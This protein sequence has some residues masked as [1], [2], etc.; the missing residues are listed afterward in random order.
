ME[1]LGTEEKRESEKDRERMIG[2]K[3]SKEEKKR[4]KDKK[5]WERKVGKNGKRGR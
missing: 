4:R 1:E 5:R 2:R 3:D